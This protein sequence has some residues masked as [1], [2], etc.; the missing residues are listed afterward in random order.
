MMENASLIT[1]MLFYISMNLGIFA[2]INLFCLCTRKY[3]LNYQV[4]SYN[5]LIINLLILLCVYVYSTTQ[6]DSSES[7]SKA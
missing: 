3:L 6:G 1:Y 2:Y 5:D 4:S 7:P